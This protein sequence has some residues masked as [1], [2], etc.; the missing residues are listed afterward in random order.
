M[1]GVRSDLVSTCVVLGSE[2]GKGAR[3]PRGLSLRKIMFGI[4]W[5]YSRLARCGDLLWKYTVDPLL[6]LFADGDLKFLRRARGVIQVVLLLAVLLIPASLFFSSSR[7]LATSGLLFDIAGVLRLFLFDEI[8]YALAGFKPNKHGNLP[9]VAVRELVMPEDSG[10]FDEKSKEISRFYYK[11]RGVLF[12]FIGFFAA[13]HRRLD[14]IEMRSTPSMSRGQAN[15]RPRRPIDANDPSWVSGSLMPSRTLIVCCQRQTAAQCPSTS[16]AGETNRAL[17]LQ[18]SLARGQVA[19][20]RP[21]RTA[22]T[23][24]LLP[25]SVPEIRL[26]LRSRIT[27]LN[28]AIGR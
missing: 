23:T 21:I 11:K 16:S 1:T 18:G 6:R 4:R 28:G 8:Q 27:F 24:E 2:F 12:L 5:E 15:S 17:K 14:R 19:L 7:L 13:T 20:P 26:G 25:G 10:I 3:C 9:S 22:V